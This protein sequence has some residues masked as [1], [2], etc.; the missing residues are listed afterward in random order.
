MYKDVGWKKK[1]KKKKDNWYVCIFPGVFSPHCLSPI[2]TPTFWMDGQQVG[3]ELHFP[4]LL[5]FPIAGWSEVMLPLQK[6]G[7]LRD[8]IA[9]SNTRRLTF[10]ESS[11]TQNIFLF[12]LL[13]LLEWIM[14]KAG[15]I[16]LTDIFRAPKILSISIQSLTAIFNYAI[17]CYDLKVILASQ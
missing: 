7:A 11:D 17:L 3:K 1:K 10:S 6:W 15:W 14:G 8:V 16:S 13:L 2:S 4:L 5:P 9:F 12:P